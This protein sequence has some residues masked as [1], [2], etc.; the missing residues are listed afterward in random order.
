MELTA[1]TQ[2]I[3]FGLSFRVLCC[4][5][6]VLNV[7]HVL[8]P[9]ALQTRI[10]RPCRE[11]RK[12]LV[13]IVSRFAKRSKSCQLLTFFPVRAT[14]R[15]ANEQEALCSDAFAQSGSDPGQQFSGAR[16]AFSTLEGRP[17]AQDFDNSPVLQDWQTA[18]DIRVVF[19]RLTPLKEVIAFP[20]DSQVAG[21]TADGLQ[22]DDASRFQIVN[23]I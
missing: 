12:I 20:G 1:V 10:F 2:R 7:E 11:F 5:E 14:A 13:A 23:V 4:V 22:S 6:H 3:V 19:D 16:I 9:T 17:S 8:T 15:Q 18:T 21:T